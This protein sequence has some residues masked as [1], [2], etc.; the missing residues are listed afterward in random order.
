MFALHTAR[1]QSDANPEKA[2]HMFKH[3]IETSIEIH[4]TPDVVWQHLMG[5][6]IYPDWNPFVKHIRGSPTVGAQ[7]EI[8]V[9][10]VGGQAMSFKPRVLTSEKSV[11]FRWL[12]HFLFSGLFDGEHY[13]LL[14]ATTNGHTKLIHGERFSGLLIPFFRNTLETQT[15]PGFEEMNQALKVRSEQF[16]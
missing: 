6:Q 1:A 9:Q 5:F 12:G 15:K 8:T 4:A 3:L 10:P 11:E 2:T 16:Q 13:F 14:N 7:L